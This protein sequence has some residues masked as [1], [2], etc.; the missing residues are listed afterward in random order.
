MQAKAIPVA[1]LTADPRNARSHDDRNIEAIQASLEK[2]GQQKPVVVSAETMVVI[3]G[4]GTVEAA[5]R[6]GW[7]TVNAVLSD[8]DGAEATAYGIADNRTAEL[9]TWD[10]DAL[11]MALDQLG[12]AERLAAGYTPTEFDNLS[13]D[14]GFLDDLGEN[15]DEL[16]SHVR[17]AIHYKIDSAFADAAQAAL[18]RLRE[19]GADIGGIVLN[20]LE[21]AAGGGKR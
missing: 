9:A 11:V 2:F 16:Q 20:A 7:E 12:E 1:D 18:K 6:L 8:L 14:L 13:V 10:E 17:K 5:R 3:A 15:D 21:A 19:K 4:N